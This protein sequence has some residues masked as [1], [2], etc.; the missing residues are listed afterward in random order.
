M[1]VPNQLR[2]TTK[3]GFVDKARNATGGSSAASVATPANY[4]S[5]DSLRTQ[6]NTLAAATYTTAVLNQM[7]VNDMVFALRTLADSGSI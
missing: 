2:P 3:L 1:A 7:S 5:T 6:L 4:A